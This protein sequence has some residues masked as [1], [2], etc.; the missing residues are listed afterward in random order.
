MADHVPSIKR[1]LLL[2]GGY[3]ALNVTYIIAGGAAMYGLEHGHELDDMKRMTDYVVDA[4]LNTNQTAYLQKLGVCKFPDHRLPHWTFTGSTFYAFTVITTIGYGVYA[5]VT[6]G[7][8]V[9]TVVYAVPGISIVAVV[10]ANVAGL[11][12]EVIEAHLARHKH[13]RR[14]KEG[15]RVRRKPSAH[16]HA[17]AND[18]TPQSAGEKLTH[19]FLNVTAGVDPS[20]ESRPVPTLE[21]LD[22]E[23]DGLV[24]VEGFKTMIACMI[25]GE[26]DKLLMDHVLRNVSEDSRRTMDYNTVVRGTALWFELSAEVP[27]ESR[28][29]KQYLLLTFAGVCVWM[30][31]WGVA[32]A[33][34]E[35]WRYSEGLWFSF[36][37]L[38]TIGFGDFVPASTIGR[39]CGFWF[40]APGLGLM[41]AFFGVL[42]NLFRRWKFKLSTRMQRD[43]RMS[44][45]LLEA[46]G[47]SSAQNR[48]LQWE[49]Y[50]GEAVVNG[51]I[52]EKKRLL[53][54][55]V[56]AAGDSFG[57]SLDRPATQPG[58]EAVRPCNSSLGARPVSTHSNSRK[59]I[60]PA[61]VDSP[62]GCLSPTSAFPLHQGAAHGNNRS[63]AFSTHSSLTARTNPTAYRERSESVSSAEQD[64]LFKSSTKFDLNA[65][66]PP[67]CGRRL[68]ASPAEAPAALYSCPRGHLLKKYAPGGG[69]GEQAFCAH[70]W[71]ER[72]PEAMLHCRSCQY[73]V[74][75]ACAAAAQG[76]LSEGGF[77]LSP[78]ASASS[79]V[80]PG[81]HTP[82]A[83]GRN[84]FLRAVGSSASLP[85][86]KLPED[87]DVINE[88]ADIVRGLSRK[89]RRPQSKL[90]SPGITLQ[91]DSPV[92]GRGRRKSRVLKAAAVND[93]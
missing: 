73:D 1:R 86:A 90:G 84:P 31:C 45:K 61:P 47:F 44:D 19:T 38:S 14:L 49:A 87:V 63:R 36:V 60:S 27:A 40:M 10:L 48:K 22:P 21:Q 91:P 39:I 81:L 17:P 2:I 30:G 37:S 46:Q 29:S 13:I 53:E 26:P 68:V 64:P 43:G 34:I 33:Q 83:H 12:A 71:R 3:L 78:Q 65:L 24:P 72:A 41:G 75:A 56:L 89:D 88:M 9:F 8:R 77:P 67:R 50:A 6:L 79:L 28:T 15:E 23:G 74:C 66:G 32:F 16:Y 92:G 5:P 35:S 4:G 85:P 55:Q 70:C 11:V 42:S 7:G 18:S 52:R 54:E 69:G 58:A 20:W 25:G 51:Q 93:R 62:I 76:G 82:V 59:S 57:R 80:S